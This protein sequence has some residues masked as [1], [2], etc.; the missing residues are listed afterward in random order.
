MI[1]GK[2]TPL[3]GLDWFPKEYVEALSRYRITTVR[4]FYGRYLGTNGRAS[5][6]GILGLGKA[7]MQ[8]TFDPLI[9]QVE[10][11]LGIEYVRMV[12]DF[13]PP[14]RH[15]GVLSPWMSGLKEDEIPEI[16]DARHLF[17]ADV[18]PVEIDNFPEGLEK[19]SQILSDI[20]EV[21]D[22]MKSKIVRGIHD[23][24]YRITKKGGEVHALLKGEVA[25]I[26]FVRRYRWNAG[27]I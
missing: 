5:I 12:K 27:E 16:S 17:L 4:Q 26:R 7:D 22:G 24:G 14:I 19:P 18:L 25:G 1:A 11:H 2:D 13:V 15:T 6:S 3:M 21:E 10:Y 20:A 9:Q 23:S 8:T